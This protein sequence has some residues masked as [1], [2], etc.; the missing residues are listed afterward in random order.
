M[1]LEVATE[2][3]L[4]S[5]YTSSNFLKKKKSER[6]SGKSLTKFEVLINFVGKVPLQ[7]PESRYSEYHQPEYTITPN[8]NYIELHCPMIMEFGESFGVVGRSGI[9][10][11][12]R[13]H[14]G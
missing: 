7:Y 3:P 11:S 4:K 6:I 9:W 1:F 8:P 5:K 14:L 2:F 10:D 13:R 12:E